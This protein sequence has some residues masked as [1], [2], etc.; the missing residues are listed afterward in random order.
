MKDGSPDLELPRGIALAW[1]MAADPQRGPKREMSLEKIVEAAVQ[2]ADADGLG[3]V[4]MAAVASRLGYT[5]MSLYRYVSAKDDLILLMQEEATGLPPDAIR[6]EEGWRA[7][8]IA[9]FRAAVDVYLQHPW[10]L[11]IPITGSPATPNSAAYMEAML[12]ALSETPLSDDERLAVALLVAGQARWYGT[13]LSAYSR[14]AREYGRSPE[15]ITAYEDGLFASL[16]SAEEFP[17]LRRAVDAGV[18]R[19]DADPFVF[20]LDRTLDG[21]GA[22]MAGLQEGVPHADP[23]PWV[24]E[25]PPAVT[26]DKRYREARKAVRDAEKALHAA[27]KLERQ[28]LADARERAGR[29]RRGA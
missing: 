29:A 16:I 17:A 9:V 27:R 4:S 7:R 14:Q 1:G 11:D 21:L 25:E 22:Y 10:V 23:R 3:A 13:I 8:L 26:E 5:T 15:E 18:F 28:A 6:D 2:I 20:G 19:S 24:E 12:D